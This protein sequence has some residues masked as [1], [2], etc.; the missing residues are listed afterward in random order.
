MILVPLAIENVA[1]FGAFT[2]AVR[3]SLVRGPRWAL[4][5]PLSSLLAVVAYAGLLLEG[6]QAPPLYHWMGGDVGPSAWLVVTVLTALV[7][8]SAF[9]GTSRLRA[10]AAP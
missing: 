9:V 3:F 2:L 7:P 6:R 4:V 1:V 5:N 10:N 8:V